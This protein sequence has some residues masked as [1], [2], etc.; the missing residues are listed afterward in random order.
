MPK[1]CLQDWSQAFAWGEVAQQG[2]RFLPN[3][4]RHAFGGVWVT[5][6]QQEVPG[7]HNSRNLLQSAAD[8]DDQAVA[9]A[10]A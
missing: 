10:H 1:P 7:R 9:L 6:A 8:R 5:Q 3:L 4:P 2:T